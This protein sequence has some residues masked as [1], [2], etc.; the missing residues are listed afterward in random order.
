MIKLYLISI[1]IWAI[2]I[3]GTAYLFEDK[4]KENGWIYLP[5]SKKNPYVIAI[6]SVTIPVIRVV[7]FVSVLV[8]IGMTKEKFEKWKE[9]FQDESN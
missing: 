1:V 5:K 7:F 9:E 6:L 2:M 4:I 3:Y 8:M